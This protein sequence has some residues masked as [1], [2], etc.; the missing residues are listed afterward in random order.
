MISTGRPELNL[1]IRKERKFNEAE[2]E[3]RNLPGQDLIALIGPKFW[4][5]NQLGNSSL[6]QKILL[7]WRNHEVHIR[8][9]LP[10]NS[11]QIAKFNR[12]MEKELR[13]FSWHV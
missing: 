4:S 11:I 3:I 9:D 1:P 13:N 5:E 2:Q 8:I 10:R 12:V 6:C 7:F